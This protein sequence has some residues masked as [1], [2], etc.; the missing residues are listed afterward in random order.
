MDT[1]KLGNQMVLQCAP[2]I[3]GLRISSLFITNRENMKQVY[4]VF[5]GSVICY[6]V[7]YVTEERVVMLLYRSQDLIDYLGDRDIRNFLMERRYPLVRLEDT[8]LVFRRRYQKYCMGS[9]EFPHEL[10]LLL[11]YPIEDVKGFIRHKGKDH[12]Y[13]GCWK[14]Y[15]DSPAKRELFQMFELAKEMLVQLL[16]NGVEIR[17]IIESFSGNEWA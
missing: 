7:L 17:D 5:K 15:A 11:G 10:G 3:E 2:L 6:Y 14:V 9:G 4:G 12:I 16:G 13:A 1:G 8:L